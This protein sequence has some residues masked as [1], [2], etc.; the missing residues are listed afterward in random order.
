M[1]SQYSA[2]EII[3]LI[4]LESAFALRVR[5]PACQIMVGEIVEQLSGSRCNLQRAGS[6]PHEIRCGRYGTRR[7]RAGHSAGRH[8]AGGIPLRVR[9]ESGA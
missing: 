9:L 2:T 7:C 8:A 1:G 3:F 6:T 5:F 4:A